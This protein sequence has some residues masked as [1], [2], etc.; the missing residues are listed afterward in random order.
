MAYFQKG[1][2]VNNLFRKGG[3][4]AR[5]LKGAA[6]TVEN[7]KIQSILSYLNPTIASLVSTAKEGGYLERI[8]NL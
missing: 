7:P 5:F 4:G 2:F 6:E 3:Y 1:S 8:K